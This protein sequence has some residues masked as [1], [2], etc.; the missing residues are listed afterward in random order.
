MIFRIILV[1]SI[2]F[3]ILPNC[4]AQTQPPQQP[5]PAPGQT[6][7]S[8]PPPDDKEDV[9]RITTNLVQVDAVVTKDGKPVPNLTAQDFEIFEDGKRQTIT[10]FA[11][12]SNLPAD[13]VK[14]AS[15]KIDPN[16]PPGP[17]APLKPNAA[18]RTIA[19]VVDDLGLSA[20]SVSAV[21]N[22]L[23]KFVSQ[24]LSPN[25]LVAII[26]TGGSMGALQQFTNDRRLINRSVEQ[27]RWNICSRVGTTYFQPLGRPGE[28]FPQS[29]LFGPCGATAS[30][31]NTMR[32][33]RFILE[34][35]GDIPGRKSMV[36]FSDSLPREEQEFDFS[37]F[38]EDRSVESTSNDSRD[39]SFLL[40]RVAEKAIRSSVV[41]YAV[42]ASG[43]QTTG[44]TAADQMSASSPA[45]FNDQMNNL[46]RTRSQ[47]IW[48]RREGA[49]LIA[50]QTG[51]FLVRN[52]NTFGLDR[53]I[54]DQTGYYLIGYR[55]SE[56]TFN[57]RFH[58]IKAKVKKS[59][60]SLR[61]RFGFYGVT[62]DD[63]N[64]TKRTPADQAVAALMSPFGAQDIELELT[65]FFADDKDRGPQVRSFVY[66]NAKDLTFVEDAQGWHNTTIELRGVVFGNNGTVV[67]QIK[68]NK[69]LSLR[70]ET[71]QSALRDGFSLQFDM[72]M[73]RPGSF[74]VRVSARDMAS[75]RVG[76][77]GQF[78]SVPDLG[79]HN[80]AVS[81]IVMRGMT[82]GTSAANPDQRGGAVP[83]VRRFVSGQ[84]VLFS[85][86][87]YNALLN[88]NKSNIV[89]QGRLFREGKE[90]YTS[91]ILNV[92]NADQPDMSR[93][94]ANGV[95][96][97]D[98]S[99]TPGSYYLQLTVTDNLRE[100]QPPVIQ[101]IDFEIVK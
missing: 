41:I 4:L 39:Y 59:G 81:G 3:S 40:Q 47:L 19:L 61:T 58:H 38:G 6:T 33:L 29:S 60:M 16:A 15:S 46:L 28:S 7:P 14:P 20:S 82:G 94:L 100:K 71:F 44:L 26:R 87:I 64:K 10:S 76:A 12:V 72:P 22:Q 88:A 56:E 24:E 54:E 62:E 30:I 90:V 91:P 50:K 85:A 25:D 17:P 52:S 79:N 69:T 97:L 9:V 99:L 11:Y 2:S 101:W 21:R 74:Q 5:K 68:N 86:A 18:R 80:L 43:L 45:Q 48:Q 55:P 51:G 34:A 65:A 35:M 13:P 66:V 83:A 98:P 70:G 78:V 8:A 73:K 23:R 96:R 75:G 49:D 77:V 1:L 27:I 37:R 84:N 53:I 89:M 31:A 32:A 95:I 36:V 93:I 92:D 63:A 67:E 42:D 57:K